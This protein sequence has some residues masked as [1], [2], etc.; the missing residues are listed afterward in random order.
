MEQSAP[1][2]MEGGPGR[3]GDGP[4]AVP[5]GGALGAGPAPPLRQLRHRAGPPL[6]GPAAVLR[7]GRPG[8]ASGPTGRGGPRSS[9]E[10]LVAGRCEPFVE[11]VEATHGGIGVVVAGAGGRA[12][13]CSQSIRLVQAWQPRVGEG[14]RRPAGRAGAA[15]GADDVPPAAGG[16]GGPGARAPARAPPGRSLRGP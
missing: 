3:A 2:A 14:V 13:S 1:P 15:A 10:L 11:Q 8:P 7:P 5:H 6:L 4:P 16:A 9:N 12:T